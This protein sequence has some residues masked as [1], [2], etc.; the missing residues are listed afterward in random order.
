MVT[1]KASTVVLS[2]RWSECEAGIHTEEHSVT[3]SCC[4]CDTLMDSMSRHDSTI[5]LLASPKLIAKK[6]MHL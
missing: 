4:Y 2:G 6:K 1:E 5:I 3:T